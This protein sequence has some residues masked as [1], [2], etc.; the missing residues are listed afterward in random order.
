MGTTVPIAMPG[1]V[2]LFITSFAIMHMCWWVHVLHH[3]NIITSVRQQ[4]ERNDLLAKRAERA[5]LLV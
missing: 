3:N 2:A 5:Q 1:D 4:G